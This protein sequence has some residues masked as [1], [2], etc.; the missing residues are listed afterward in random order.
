LG[1]VL[2]ECDPHGL[3]AAAGV[4]MNLGDSRKSIGR[5]PGWREWRRL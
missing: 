5:R 2:D 3:K 1:E 4:T